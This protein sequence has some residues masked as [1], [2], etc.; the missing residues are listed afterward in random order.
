MVLPDAAILSMIQ[1]DLLPFMENDTDIV[2]IGLLSFLLPSLPLS[3]QSA[4]PLC[5]LCL[6]TEDPRPAPPGQV[7]AGRGTPSRA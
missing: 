5:P 2:V 7:V 6:R 1:F 4:H 3:S